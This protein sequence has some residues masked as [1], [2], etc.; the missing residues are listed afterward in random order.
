MQTDQ[1]LQLRQ[2]CTP[3]YTSYLGTGRTIAAEEGVSVLFFR[4]C[5]PALGHTNSVPAAAATRWATDASGSPRSMTASMMREISYSTLRIGLYEPCKNLFA[6]NVEGDIG[7][8]RKILAGATSG[9]IGSAIANPTDLVKVRPLPPP[10]VPTEPGPPL[11]ARRRY[12][13]TPGARAAPTRLVSLSR[14]RPTRFASRRSPSPFTATAS[15]HW[16]RSSEPRASPAST[17]W[18]GA[19]VA[20]QR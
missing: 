9:A 7:L 11:R 17:R 1:Q 3:K 13:G 16:P 5:A 20:A 2:A 14:P 15:T 12:V 18:D 8:L 4:G 10:V 19:V 6:P